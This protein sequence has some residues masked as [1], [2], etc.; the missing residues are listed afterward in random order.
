MASGTRGD[1][2]RVFEIVQQGV[3]SDEHRKFVER[4]AEKKGKR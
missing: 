3:Q 1:L 4:L 2:Q